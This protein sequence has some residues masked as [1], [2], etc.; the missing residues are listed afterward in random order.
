MV[1]GETA[2]VHC[3]L[4]TSRI[5]K[6]EEAVSA[7][8]DVTQN[9]K[10]TSSETQQDL[11]SIS[12]AKVPPNDV[13]NDIK[14]AHDIGET[15]YKTF[16]HGCLEKV[17]QMKKF[18][19]PIKMNKLKTFSNMSKKKVNAATGRSVIPKADRSLFGRI[20]VMAQVGD[21]AMQEVLVHPLGPLPWA[22]PTPDGF[23]RKTNKAD[24]AATLQKDVPLADR[25]LYLI[26]L[27]QSL[28][29]WLLYRK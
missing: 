3:D 26:T 24:L 18:H 2:S 5:R 4:Q 7:V 12:T 1:Q 10:N 21:V 29:Q 13:R 19:N 22:L 16:R 27:P 15:C 23:F 14:K 11:V 20:I 8:V 6:D 17:P 25:I 9:W 28:M